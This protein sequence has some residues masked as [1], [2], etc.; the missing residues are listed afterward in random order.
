MFRLVSWVFQ[1]TPALSPAKVTDQFWSFLWRERDDILC[2]LSSIPLQSLNPELERSPD[3]PTATS[4][5]PRPHHHCH[6]DK[7]LGLCDRDMAFTTAETSL[8]KVAPTAIVT[9]VGHQDG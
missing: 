3:P 7:G 2:R 5:P 9:F 4:S 1:R 8:F 6:L